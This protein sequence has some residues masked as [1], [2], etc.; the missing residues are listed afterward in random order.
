LE[1]TCRKPESVSMTASRSG[2]PSA[3]VRSVICGAV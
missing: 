3:A 2:A 1:R